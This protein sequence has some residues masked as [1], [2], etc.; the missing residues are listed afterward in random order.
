MKLVKRLGEAGN[1]N[2]KSKGDCHVKIEIKEAEGID[3]VLNS[4]VKVFYASSIEQLCRSVLVFFN[5]KNALVEINDNGALPYVLAARIEA[6]VKAIMQTDKDFLLD[7]IPENNYQST[8]RHFRLSRLYLPGNTPYMMLNAGIHQP[9][10]IILDLEDSVSI[11][12]KDEA[13]ILVRNALRSQNFY[14]VERMVRINQG[15]RGVE[16]LSY[17]I[18]HNVH[19]ILIPKCETVD[20]VLLVEKEIARLK[21]RHAIVHDIYLMPIIE[22]ALGVENAFEIASS[23]LNIA[24]MAIGLEDYTADIGVQRSEGAIESL[25]ARMRIVNACNAANIQPIDSV[26]SDVADMEALALNVKRSKELG[27][28]GMGC[29]HPRQISVIHENF[30]PDKKEIEKAKK[31]ILAFDEAERNKIAVVSIGSKM[32]DPPV[33]KRQLKIL[34]LAIEM[35][36]VRVNWR[37]CDEA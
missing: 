3:F 28:Q 6:A 30:A 1:S 25:Y 26:F 11:Q 32:I 16:D 34:E 14:G 20:G 24:A 15:Q 8:K 36:L 21:E 31:I 10:A 5:I 7:L 33:V 17:L 18:P 37:D 9:N 27:F 22:S 2:S 4:K 19:L 12:K 29:I 35:K 13:R 23:S